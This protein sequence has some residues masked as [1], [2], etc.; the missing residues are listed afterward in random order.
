[1]NT[2]LFIARKIYFDK[3]NRQ[4]LSQKIIRISLYG[5]ALSFGIM[6]IS[7]AVMNGFKGKIRD[8]I[9]GFG[10]H[11]QILNL[12]SRNTYEL[13]PIDKDQDFVP[14]I[15]SLDEVQAI[16][17]FATK[18]GMIKTP[19][20][21]HGIIFKGVDYNY[22][23]DF[24]QGH[25]IEGKL[26]DLK[27][28]T[29][30]KE[31]IVSE[32][33]ARTLNLEV[34]D[35]PVLYF[36]NQDEIIPRLFQPT[37]CG[38]YNTHLEDFD[39]LF[40]LGDINQVRR[41]NDWNSKQISGFEVEIKNFR[42]VVDVERQIREIVFNYDEEETTFFRTESITSLYPQLF[43]WLRI[44]DMNVYVLMILLILVAGFNMIS[45]LLVL[46]LERSTMIGVLKALGSP[47]WNIRKVFLYLSYFLTGRGIIWGNAIGL[48]I[49]FAQKYLNIIKL[50]P[51]TY[52]ID[53]V[54]MNLTFANFI[55]LNVGSILVT[56]VMLIIPSHLVSKISPDKSIRFD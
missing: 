40:V 2:E 16:H 28:D 18:T 10:S 14:Q 20:Y 37:I 39:K 1:M 41:V 47:T 21:N 33:I 29:R 55:L 3:S 35:K 6:L 53:V 8:K 22:D 51:T 26:P 45:G 46:I 30:T 54:P 7:I 19:Q 44:I 12:E 42:K 32:H 49:I 43:D 27:E 9:I 17:A 52:Y 38:I 34:G 48:I 24:F 36:I 4:F 56:T 25:L 50:D 31:I 5:I 11:I 23:W 15:A 13:S